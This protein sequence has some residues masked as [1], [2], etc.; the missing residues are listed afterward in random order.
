MVP[1]V[2]VELRGRCR[3]V[4]VR[5]FVVVLVVIIVVVV[6]IVI[7]VRVAP[8]KHSWRK[9]PVVILSK[10]HYRIRKKGRINKKNVSIVISRFPMVIT[11][12]TTILTIIA[13][14]T[15]IMIMIIM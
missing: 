9:Y 15:I 13:I 12:T 7:R 8:K 5:I 6:I 3:F 11:I 14:A 4:M 10:R 2:R 1:V